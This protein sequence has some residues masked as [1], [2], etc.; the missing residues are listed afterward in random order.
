MKESIKSR[1]RKRTC[2]CTPVSDLGKGLVVAVEG[3]GNE[4]A[5][6]LFFRRVFKEA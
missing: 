3:E 1:G 5:Q 2:L 6:L 4:S